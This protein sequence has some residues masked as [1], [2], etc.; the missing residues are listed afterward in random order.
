MTT[1]MAPTHHHGDVLTRGEGHDNFAVS[2]ERAAQLGVPQIVSTV[3]LIEFVTHL[4][5]SMTPHRIP[6]LTV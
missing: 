5:G 6:A 1:T 3:G 4:H 2:P